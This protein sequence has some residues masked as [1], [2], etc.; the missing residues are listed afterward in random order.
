MMQL[1]G[2]WMTE[3]EVTIEALVYPFDGQKKVGQVS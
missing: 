2:T 1:D 3:L